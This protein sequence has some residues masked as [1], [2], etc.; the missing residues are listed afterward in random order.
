MEEL[1]EEHGFE[2]REEFMIAPNGAAKPSKRL[3]R[4]L[5]PC[6]NSIKGQVFEFPSDF[7]SSLP[8]TFEPKTWR[9]NV[10]FQGWRSPQKNW[11]AWVEKMAPL[12]EYTWKKA[13]I[14]DAILNSTYEIRR[15]YDFIVGLAEKWC[16]ETKSFIFC[17]GEATITLEDMMI[18]GYSVSG[19]PVFSPLETDELLETEEKLNQARTELSRTAARKAYQGAW[20]KKFMDSESEIE[21]EAFLVLWLSRFVL[22]SSF[23]VNRV[24]S[25]NV[26]PIAVHLAKGTRIALAP[27]VLASIYIDLNLFKEKIASLSVVDKWEDKDSKLEVT[28]RSPFQL[29]QIWAWERFTDLRPKPNLIKNGEPRFARWHKLMINVENVRTVLD[30]AQGS[31]DWRPYAKPLNN[32]KLPMFYVEK[33]VSVLADGDLSEELQSFARCMCVSELVGLEKDCI[34]QYLPHR[35]AM[36]FGMDQDLPTC[37]A[38]AND[39]PELA[40]SYYCKPITYT[41]LCIPSRH[42]EAGVTTQYLKWWKQSLSHLQG[43]SNGALPDKRKCWSSKIIP[44]RPKG[45]IEGSSIGSRKAHMKLKEKSK[46]DAVPTSPHFSVKSLKRSPE[47]SKM[48]INDADSSAPLGCPVKKDKKLLEFSKEKKRVSGGS[49]SAELHSKRLSLSLEV[50]K[51][52]NDAPVPPGFPPKSNLLAASDSTSED[53]LT[54]GELLRSRKKHDGFCNEEVISAESWPSQSDTLSS[55]AVCEVVRVFEPQLQTEL[56]EKSRWNEPSETSIEDSTDIQLVNS[57]HD[58]VRMQG[59]DRDGNINDNEISER[60]EL[61]LEEWVSRLERIVA[62]LKAKRFGHTGKL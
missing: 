55:T 43:A 5:K 42:Y 3:A 25:R 13:G 57:A 26:F 14:Y 30:S 21:H 56:V 49:A 35:V 45:M 54:I 50:K 27:A 58:L 44:K 53:N 34:E 8:P 59:G 16:P 29:L 22:P 32:W 62:K 61:H 15:N 24:I 4:F 7:L 36:Q 39:S 47:T 38:R 60:P 2:V 46:G 1:E 6:V 17:W 48:N 33:E 11:G 9:L 18:A 52:A 28:T 23:R 19:S 12:H 40:W 51:E 20:L 31:F 37:V 10:N 41:N